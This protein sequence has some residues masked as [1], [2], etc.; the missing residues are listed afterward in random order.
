M[1]LISNLLISTLIISVILLILVAYLLNEYDIEMKEYMRLFLYTYGVIGCF[2]F[3]YKKQ[4]SEKRPITAAAE[5]FNEITDSQQI[6][7]IMPL[8][9]MLGGDE[10]LII[11]NIP[12]SITCNNISTK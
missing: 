11:D 10:E 7:G 5:V 2:L 1:E 6:N 12:T 9:S 3:Y 4:I 8:Q